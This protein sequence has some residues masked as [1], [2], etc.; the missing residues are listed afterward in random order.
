MPDAPVLDWRNRLAATGLTAFNPSATGA[1][2][3]YLPGPPEDDEAYRVATLVTRLGQAVD[4]RMTPEVR[5]AFDDAKLAWEAAVTAYSLRVAET[6]RMVDR[7]ARWVEGEQLRVNTARL[8][9]N[10]GRATV[11]GQ[12]YALAPE[13]VCRI[14]VDFN[15]D[16]SGLVLRSFYE[17]EATFA[18]RDLRATATPVLR[19]VARAI[20]VEGVQVFVGVSNGPT[21]DAFKLTA[22]RGSNSSYAYVETYDALDPTAQGYADQLAAIGQASLLL[23]SVAALAP[24]TRPDDASLTHLGNGGDAYGTGGNGG[25]RAAVT[26]RAQRAMKLPA[27]SADA[28]A[29]VKTLLAAYEAAWASAPRPVYPAAWTREIIAPMPI[30]QP[31][32][33]SYSI[34]AALEEIESLLVRAKAIG[35]LRA[36]TR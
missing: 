21:G 35:E 12:T 15:L 20:G 8:V 17:P 16:T 36:F 18:Q 9:P 28:V 26:L 11:N 31:R 22:Q 30:L 13:D 3:R 25:S 34:A 7:A 27:A 14:P 29:E 32:A 5:R 10:P 33:A 2:R 6:H 23:G 1:D 4:E 24:G 19:V